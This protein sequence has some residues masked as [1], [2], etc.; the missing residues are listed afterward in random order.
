MCDLWPLPECPAKVVGCSY[1]V[2]PVYVKVCADVK[3]CVDVCASVYSHAGVC[4]GVCVQVCV[5]RLVSRRV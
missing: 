4:V 1:G 2:K 5:C 3:V